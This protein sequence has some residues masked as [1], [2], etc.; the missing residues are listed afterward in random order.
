VKKCFF[1]NAPARAHTRTRGK[2]MR[3]GFKFA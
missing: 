1:Y 3:A 2:R